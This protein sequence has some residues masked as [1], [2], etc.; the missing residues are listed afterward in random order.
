MENKK[1]WFITGTSTG[2]GRELAAEVLAQGHKVIATARKPETVRDL[3]EKYPNQ[4]KAVRLDVTK[5]EEVRAAIKS[6]TDAFGRIDVVVNNAGYALVGAIEEATDEQIRRQFETNTFGAMDVMRAA[7][8]ILREQKSGHILNVSSVVGLVAIPSLGYYSASKFA[9]EAFSESLAA[10]VAPLGIKVTIIE[11]GA[12]R[13][14]GLSENNLT[15]AANRIADYQS[16]T[17][18]IGWFE[19]ING[20]Q[21]GDAKKAAKAMIQIVE[22]ENPPLRL[23]LGS[24][25]PQMIQGK[26]DALKK[27]FEAWH[28]LTVSTDFDNL[29]AAASQI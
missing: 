13:T 6:A 5:P 28:D 18:T 29:Q 22:T 12:F 16:T 21:P 15:I 10:E 2:F 24:D 3:E 20:K 9:L 14:N 11:P 26:L 4:A 19:S 25:A 23:V 8:P 1:V 17:D 27:D 7:L